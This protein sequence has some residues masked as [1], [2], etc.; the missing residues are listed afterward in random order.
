MKGSR[1]RV[2]AGVPENKWLL[3]VQNVWNKGIAFA[4]SAEQQGEWCRNNPPCHVRFRGSGGFSQVCLWEMATQQRRCG[5]S[6][7]LSR[8]GLWVPWILCSAACAELYIFLCPKRGP[9]VSEREGS[10]RRDL[11]AG[12]KSGASFRGHSGDQGRPG[13]S[14]KRP[15]QTRVHDNTTHHLKKFG[16]M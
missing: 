6:A 8:E 3:A 10:G 5:F 14:P 4:L 16:V 15:A 2:S 13:I 12:E 9:G 1:E 7:D 11:D